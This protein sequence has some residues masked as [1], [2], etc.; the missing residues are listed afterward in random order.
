MIVEIIIVDQYFKMTH[1]QEQVIVL[2]LKEGRLRW[3]LKYRRTLCLSTDV[4][5]EISNSEGKNSIT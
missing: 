5:W 4:N 2:K 3:L 1:L